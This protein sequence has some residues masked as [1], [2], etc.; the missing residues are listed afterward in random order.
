M[1]EEQRVSLAKKEAKYVEEAELLAQEIG[2]LHLLVSRKS[3]DAGVL[4][5]SVTSKDIGDVLEANGI[6]I[7]RRKI[8]LEQPIKSIGNV[9]VEVRPHREVTANLLVSVMPEEG[10]SVARTMQRGEESDQIVRELEA[11]VAETM[12]TSGSPATSES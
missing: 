4:F 2:Q 5:G 6:N 12:E 10:K 7:D 11:K 1:V 3:G 8:L 9:T